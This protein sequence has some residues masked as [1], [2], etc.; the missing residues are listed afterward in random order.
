MNKIKQKNQDKLKYDNDKKHRD[1]KIKD[2]KVYKREKLPSKDRKYKRNRVIDDYNRM[3]TAAQ[4]EF[5][6]TFVDDILDCH[7]NGKWLIGCNDPIIDIE[8]RKE[9]KI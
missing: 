5:I 2:A 7:K 1:K 3:D 8:K 6:N 9:D 4:E